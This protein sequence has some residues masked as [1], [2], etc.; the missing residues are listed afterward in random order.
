MK[1]IGPKDDGNGGE[2]EL[3]EHLSE[4]TER[5]GILA[6]D[7]SIDLE[8][9]ATLSDE[10]F[11]ELAAWLL[12]GAGGL[13]PPVEVP[14]ELFGVQLDGIA[15]EGSLSLSDAMS[16]PQAAAWV[17]QVKALLPAGE[18]VAV[19]P[20]E[21]APLIDSLV[22]L[23]EL[24]SEE[25]QALAQ[26]LGT[27][28]M[29]LADAQGLSEAL[30]ADAGP[31]AEKAFLINEVLPRMSAE[32]LNTALAEAA[33]STGLAEGLVGLEKGEPI[34]ELLLRGLAVEVLEPQAKPV[35][36][37]TELALASRSRFGELTESLSAQT[38]GVSLLAE[39]EDE[40][41]A[42]TMEELEVD[43]E[44]DVETDVDSGDLSEGEDMPFE[45]DSEADSEW[46]EAERLPTAGPARKRADASAKAASTIEPVANELESSASATEGKEAGAVR[47]PTLSQPQTS[48]A[49]YV[50]PAENYARLAQAMKVSAARG[51]STATLQLSPPELGKVKLNITVKDGVMSANVVT[52]SKEA[53]SVLVNNLAE[54]KT[55]LE[56]QG[57][58]V[59]NFDIRYSR[60]NNEAERDQGAYQQGSR[61]R[62]QHETS[63]GEGR[64]AAPEGIVATT[65]AD[66][67]IDAVV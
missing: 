49:R 7:G 33:R 1:H 25:S 14:V 56:Q 38:E 54:L 22:G 47:A 17:E 27:K 10:E 40:A 46:E 61:R 6:R 9:V 11:A 64:E 57:I 4:V 55:N 37:L 51:G 39:G 29:A 35:D 12:E 41:D 21:G 31:A 15:I 65:Y 45:L 8:E 53:R 67:G 28:L 5:L 23:D 50:D 60:D 44:T 62:S 36:L 18:E 66:G 59:E 48:Q 58:K 52:E 13:F 24:T 20:I 63:D 32:E 43:V 26:A 2:S 42:L 19:G 3:P 30:P 34:P 16:D